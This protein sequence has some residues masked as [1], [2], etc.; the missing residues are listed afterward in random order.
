MEVAGHIAALRREGELL[1][2]AAHRGGLDAPVPTCPAWNLRDLVRHI[3]GIHRWAAAIVTR[4]RTGPFD[5][6]VEL[7]GHWP[8][9]ADLIDWFTEGH[10]SL[11]RALEQAPADL[12]AFAF[13]PAP[14][15]LA[16]WARRQAHETG[17]H[18]ADAEAASGSITPY[19]LDM[20]VDGI[21]ELLFGFA[22]RPGSKLV[23][24]PP[25]A[26]RLHATDADADWLIRIGQ[27]GPKSSRE[28]GDADCVVSAATSD[29][30]LLLWNRRTADGLD[31][32]G[33]ATLL[34]AW[35]DNVQVQWR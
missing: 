5:P 19:P 18:R 23:A 1:G 7:E 9:D 33:D 14:S 11:V 34:E 24:D 28:P 13:L 16:F 4:T 12:D 30:F 20:A 3:G 31:V 2:S 10:S 35:R 27:G 6:F 22:A 25:R 26:V 8:A 29:L 17:I 21:E 32:G 15:P